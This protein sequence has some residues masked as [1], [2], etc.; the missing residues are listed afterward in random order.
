MGSEIFTGSYP[1]MVVGAYVVLN[2]LA[3][4]LLDHWLC[5]ASFSYRISVAKRVIVCFLFA[6]IASLPVLALFIRD[7]IYK[8]Y[9]EKYSYIWMGFLMYFGALILVLTLFE[10]IVRLIAA[11][12]GHGRHDKDAEEDSSDPGKTENEQY[13]SMNSAEGVQY[14]DVAASSEA[15]GDA[16]DEYDEQKPGL[17]GR[18]IS[19][20]LI[21]LMIGAAVGINVYGMEHARDTVVTR[22]DVKIDK[23]VKNTDTLRVAFISDF[24]LSYNSDPSM[25]WQMAEKINREKPDVVLVG[26]DMF[27][28]SYSAVRDH[29]EYIKAFKSIKAKDGVYWV[30]GNHDVEEPLFCGFAM[31][32]PEEAVRTKKMKKFLKKCGFKILDDKYTAICKGEVQLAGRAD[33]Y[34]PVDRAKK[35]MKPEDFMSDLDNDKPIIVLEHEPDDFKALSGIGTD[36]TFAAHTHAGQM[37]PGNLVVQALHDVAYGCKDRNGMKVIVTS[38]VGCYGP[39]IRVLTDSEIVIADIHFSK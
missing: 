39:P 16:D 28:S 19:G 30:Y 34:K 22:Y 6:A 17:A 36:I 24:H 35:R 7:G 25:I 21:V 13:P 38:G 26:G 27:S 14:Q 8:Y 18:V 20:I 15:A 9:L 12:A 37:F 23:H 29:K 5:N 2:L 4:F 32:K 31:A 3:L 1:E 10:I 11:A 33:K